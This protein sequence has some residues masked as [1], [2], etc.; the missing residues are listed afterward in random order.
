MPYPQ[1]FAYWLPTVGIGP[2]PMQEVH[3]PL[4]D[5]LNYRRGDGS[6][7]INVVNLNGANFNV[8]ENFDTAPLVLDPILETALNDG[9]VAKLQAAGM[10]VMLTITGSGNAP[11][12][13]IGWG[14]LSTAQ[15]QTLVEYFNA[16]V[17]GTWGLDGIDIDNE[18]PSTFDNLV[19][20]VTAM[21]A[22]FAPDKA[23]SKAL[24]DEQGL[25]PQLAPLLDFGGI[26]NYGDDAGWLEQVFET[27]VAEGMAADKMTIGVNAGPVAQSSNFTSIGTA[28]TLAGWQPA[29]GQK[30]GMMLWSFSQDIQQFTADPQN[31][32]NLMW[33]N[34]NDHSWQQ[35]MIA[36]FEGN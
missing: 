25:L 31:Q 29:G 30:L 22:G 21:R 17:L 1:L 7:Q 35:A 10:K 19:A 13:P 26:M 28:Q 34:E 3:V 14:S 4:T 16:Q 20:T 24:W 27:Y 2:A 23:I 5:V 33:R 6:L 11:G 15:T 36:V 9:S 8:A 18:Y 12:T 32:P